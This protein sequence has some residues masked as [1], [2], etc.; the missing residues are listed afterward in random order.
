MKHCV[1]YLDLA[2]CDYK[3]LSVRAN[4]KDALKAL[5]KAIDDNEEIQNPS[6]Y[7]KYHDSQS[8]IS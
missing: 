1:L 8:I 5:N 4:Y 6:D 2:L 7:K 3:I